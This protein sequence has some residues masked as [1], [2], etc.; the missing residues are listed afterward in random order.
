[1]SEIYLYIL[2]GLLAGALSGLVGIG[3]GILIVPAL[4]MLFGMTQHQ[5]QG[6]SLAV[7]IPPV[8][9]LAAMTYYK[10]GLIDVKVAGLICAGFV[11]GALLGAKVAISLS[12]A[13]M[14]K[15]FGLV[16]FLISLKMIFNK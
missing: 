7:L 11:V 5:A 14:K 9:I 4:V 13:M 12:E 10:E 15:V 2:L 6:T 3:G 1:M 16:L 8:G